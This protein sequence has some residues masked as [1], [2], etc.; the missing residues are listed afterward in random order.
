MI[1]AMHYVTLACILAGMAYDLKIFYNVAIGL[2]LGIAI[3][4]WIDYRLHQRKM[5]EMYAEVADRITK[6]ETD[7]EKADATRSDA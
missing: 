3:S 4:Y 2:S 6:M 7:K 5:D 1:L